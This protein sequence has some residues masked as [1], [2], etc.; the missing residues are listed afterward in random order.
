MVAMSFH[1][2]GGKDTDSELPR[3][4]ARELTFLKKIFTRS[5]E[6]ANV[7]DQARELFGRVKVLGERR[8]LLTHGYPNSYWSDRIEYTWIKATET[9]HMVEQHTLT[10]VQVREIAMSSLKLAGDLTPL[11][12]SMARFVTNEHEGKPGGEITI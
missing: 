4:L 7:R 5:P 2:F 12:E 8:H 1:R 10:L 11:A 3:M 6:L 9:M